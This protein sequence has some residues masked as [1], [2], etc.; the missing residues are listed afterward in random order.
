MFFYLLPVNSNALML[1]P[2]FDDDDKGK[3]KNSKRGVLPKHATQVMKSW[4]FQHIV[5]SIFNIVWHAVNSFEMSG[6]KHMIFAF[7][8][9]YP[10]EDEKRQIAG[11]TNLSLLQVNNWWVV[12]VTLPSV[13]LHP[14]RLGFYTILLCCQISWHIMAC[15]TESVCRYVAPNGS[16]YTFDWWYHQHL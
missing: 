9:P 14:R 3:G 2:D 1:S 6:A 12:Q 16:W 15:G 5:V 8:H 13:I 10:T 4:L 11:Q 7:Q